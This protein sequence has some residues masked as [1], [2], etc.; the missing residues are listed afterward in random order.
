MR[1]RYGFIGIA[2]SAAL[3]GGGCSGAPGAG[4]TASAF[5]PADAT[6]TTS[7]A[8]A[9]LSGLRVAGNTLVDGAGH[10]VHLQGVNRS[11]TEYACVQG[12]GLFDG[13]NDAASVK[14]MT[15]WHVNIVRVLLNEDCWL[16][17]NG[18]KPQYAAANYRQAIADYVQLLHSYGMY[19]E[20]S[21]Y[22]AAPGSHRSSFAD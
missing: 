6:T 8:P 4:T 14:A 12:W 22:W 10:A 9:T 16:G 7:A 13:P 17:I 21:L 20:L 19:V 2:F 1:V 15:T 11:G 18:I 5:V 3:L